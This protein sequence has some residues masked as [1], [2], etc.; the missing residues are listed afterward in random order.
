M[1]ETS[2]PAGL[3]VQQWDAKYFKEYLNRNW[4]KPFMGT[5][6]SKAIQVNEQLTKKP[7]DS[8]TFTLVN[9]LTGSATNSSGTLEGNEEAMVSRSHKVTIEE[10]SHAVKFSKFEAQKTAFDLR[11][12]HKDT[13]MDW[14]MELDRDKIIAA[15]GDINGVA[16]GSASEAN[17]DAWLVDNADRCLFGAALS[18]NSLN[19]H[20]L[21]LANIDNTADKLTPDALSLMKRLAKTCNPKV[22]PIKAKGSIGDSDAYICLAPSLLM[23]DL[24]NNATFVQANREARHRGKGNPLFDGADYMWGNIAIYEMEDIGVLSGVGAG[25]IDVA[26]TYLLGAQAI[27]IAWSKRPQTVVEEFDYY[28][29]VGIAVKQWYE[30]EKLR[31]GSGSGDTDDLKDHG[32]VTGFFAAVAD[33]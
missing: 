2:V 33:A 25:G 16:Y 28:R 10:Y 11:Q 1:A 8:V 13:L 31:F 14:N 22:R 18:N 30:V 21:S 7:G 24:E 32:V 3:T 5:G 27:G 17:K 6:S 4:F 15:L 9:R 19:D 20:S 26:P 29:K 23:R 12:A